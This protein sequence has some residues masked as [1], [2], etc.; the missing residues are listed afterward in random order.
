VLGAA[1][2]FGGA[3]CGCGGGAGAG[4]EGGVEFFGEEFEYWRRLQYK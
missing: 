3:V 1:A 4:V 2:G